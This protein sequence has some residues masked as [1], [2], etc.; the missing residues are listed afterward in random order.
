MVSKVKKNQPTEAEKKR[1]KAL[2]KKKGFTG[3]KLAS[4]LKK[5]YLYSNSS[6]KGPDAAVRAVMDQLKIGNELDKSGM[7]SHYDWK[8][9]SK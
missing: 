6:G 5:P 8:G 1:M 2:L 9:R 7:G 3:E 4:A